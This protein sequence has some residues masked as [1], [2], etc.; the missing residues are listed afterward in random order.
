MTDLSI[1][2]PASEL[3]TTELGTTELSTTEAVNNGLLN[4]HS[5]I[6]SALDGLP[7]APIDP[8][9]DYLTRLRES[10]AAISQEEVWAV[11]HVLFQAWQDGRKIF[12]CGNGGSAATASHMANDLNKFTIFEGKPRMKAIAL[13]DNLPLITAWANDAKYEDIFAEQLINLV[14]PGDIL[15]AISASG[16]SLNVI[17]ALET[18][19]R[20]QATTIGF[21][22]DHGGR[23]KDLVDYC[24][25]IPD[26]YIGRQED[27]HMILDHMI[28]YTL[29]WMIAAVE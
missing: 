26:D 14:E 12:I 19:R 21:T 20:F 27:G 9:N 28:S 3:G 7:S 15:L 25:F 29:R 18:A 13:T 10:V 6:S 24:I 17:R 8:V 23:L 22:G 5:Q 4:D 16:N 2:P 11:I 1:R